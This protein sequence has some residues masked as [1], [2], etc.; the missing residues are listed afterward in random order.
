MKG[1]EEEGLVDL[2]EKIS[3]EQSFYINKAKANWLSPLINMMLLPDIWE[4]RIC[5][6]NRGN[7]RDF[8][9]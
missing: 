2:F 5:Y 1:V 4:F 6:S 8:G 9:K 7:I 3:K